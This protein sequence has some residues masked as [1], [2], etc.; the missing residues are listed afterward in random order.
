[1]N[2]E[3]DHAVLVVGYTNSTWILKNQWGR[4]WGESGYMRLTRNRNVTGANCFIGYYV[5]Y[6]DP[7]TVSLE[8]SARII[9]YSVVFSFI[10]LL[11][12]IL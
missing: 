3:I 8:L 11:V 6:L 4:S 7:V 2:A 10:A 12:L 9:T 5:P 1:M